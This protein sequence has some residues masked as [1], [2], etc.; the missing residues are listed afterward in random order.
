MMSTVPWTA[1][2]SNRSKESARLIRKVTSASMAS[3]PAIT[4][5]RRRA[6]E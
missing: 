4:S 5:A 3:R 6:R 1:T 2:L